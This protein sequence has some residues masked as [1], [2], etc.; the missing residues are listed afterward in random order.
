MK[1]VLIIK[2]VHIQEGIKITLKGCPVVAKGSGGTVGKDSN[3]INVELNLL[4]K[5]EVPGYK[6]WGD[7]KALDC[8]HKL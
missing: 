3:H 2:T 4:G 7:R 6:G 1:N 8:L 5:K